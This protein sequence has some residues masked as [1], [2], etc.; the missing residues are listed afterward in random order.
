MHT[1]LPEPVV[2]AIKRWGIEVKSPIIGTPDIFFPKAMG[3]FI[4]FFLKSDW[5]IISLNKHFSLM[6]LATQFPQCFYQV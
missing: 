2:P 4:S 3:K 5:L 6:I 1:D